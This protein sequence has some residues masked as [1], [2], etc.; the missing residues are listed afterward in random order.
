MS[1]IHISEAEATRDFAGLLAQV[2][3][4]TEVVIDGVLPAIRLSVVA[5]PS[6]QTLSKSIAMIEADTQRVNG[7]MM[8]G[9]FA[10]DLAEIIA[11]RKPRDT[12]AWD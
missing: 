1:A 11:G 9:G 5:R 2:R 3:S 4:G 8:D 10:D 6:G 7:T 12:S